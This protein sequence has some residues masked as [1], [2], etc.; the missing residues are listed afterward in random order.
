[1]DNLFQF[2]PLTLF[3]QTSV[4]PAPLA[5]LNSMGR[6]PTI[7]SLLNN[8]GQDFSQMLSLMLMSSTFGGTDSGLG[9]I[10]ALFGGLGSL[11]GGSGSLFGAGNAMMG[12][13]ASSGSAF[14]PL[15][16]SLFSQSLPMQM[17][18]DSGGLGNQFSIFDLFNSQY[19][20]NTSAQAIHINQFDAEKSVG[21]DGRNANCGPTALTIAL[22]GAGINF[23]MGLSDGKI[24]DLMRQQMVADSSRDGV[25]VDGQRVESEHNTYTN[26]N[27]IV[28]GAKATGANAQRIDPDIANIYN[29]IAAGGTVVVSGTFIGKQ[30][31]PWTGDRG[32]DN[33][34]APGGSGKHFVAVTGYNAQTGMFTVNDPAR[35]TPLEV[36]AGTLSYFMESNAGAVSIQRGF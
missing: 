24:I 6:K 12:G 17:G 28:R 35:R 25:G 29:A 5:N 30:P 31:L 15:M 7:G 4:Q 10:S 9:G 13:I 16:G 32:H 1:M 19:G 22:R 18:T 20:V 27:D 3:G 23:G 8:G 34:T 36:S 11:F 26:L 2:N 21:G 14:S 33:Q